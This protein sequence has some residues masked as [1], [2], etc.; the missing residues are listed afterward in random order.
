M[1]ILF[2]CFF[3]ISAMLIATTATAQISHGGE[4]LFNKSMEKAASQSIELQKIDNDLYLVEDMDAAKGAGPLRIGVMQETNI[5]VIETAKVVKESGYVHYLLAVSSPDATFTSLHFST[6]ELPEGAELFF[7]DQSGDF[8]LGSFNASDIK[9][10]GTFY[11]Q[12]IPGSTAFI[13]YSVPA[14][15][16]P[17]RLIISQVCHG[18]KDIFLTINSNYEAMEES[19]K[20]SHGMAE[21]NCHINVVC[22]DGDDWRDQIRSVV[23]IEIIAGG[24]AYMCSGALINNARQDKTPYVLSAYHCQDLDAPVSS[25]IAYFL[26]Q[27]NTCN[28]TIGPGN[29]SVTGATIKAKF[30]YEY[31]SDFLLL[32]LSSN[33]PDAYKPYYAGWEKANMTSPTPGVCI[34][35]PG[36][37]Y[38]K[39]SFAKTITRMTGSYSKFWQVNWYTG[40]DNK[41]VTEQGS[42]GSPLFNSDKRIIGQLWAG[43]SA[44]NKMDGADYYG[45][46]YSSWN[47]DGTNT[48]SLKPWLDPDNSNISQLDGINYQSSTEDIITPEE[49]AAGRTNL[50]VYPNPSTG[51]VHF[52]IDALGSANYKVFDASGKCVKEGCTVLTT[53]VQAIDL[54]SLP[55]GN[56]VLQLHTSSR[57]YTGKVV[58]K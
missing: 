23:A 54:S 26:Y 38:K 11:T 31:G 28:G 53:T 29:K 30:S 6:F 12:A 19:L 21:G 20:G 9:D 51:I 2:K 42:S 35:H 39:I 46:I 7:Y 56:Y 1:K 40:T 50:E 55:K 16:E 8:V 57:S 41:G 34:H 47:G 33:V 43:S 5:D 17:G 24:Y 25:F 4:P 45:R 22:P 44:C 14:D 37:D 27:T 48:G 58:I 10:D 18:Y 52:D 13:E 3:A 15:K 36:G 32:L 49:A